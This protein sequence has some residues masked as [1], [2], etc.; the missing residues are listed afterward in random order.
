MPLSVCS[1]LHGVNPWLKMKKIL[2]VAGFEIEAT[3]TRKERDAEYLSHAL[4][5]GEQFPKV[6]GRAKV[7]EGK[8]KIHNVML[9]GS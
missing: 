5:V 4:K 6:Q 9:H 3:F 1:A 8:G 7:L 2:K